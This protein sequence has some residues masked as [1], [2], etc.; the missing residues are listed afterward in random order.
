MLSTLF[1]LTLK[2]Y[3]VYLLNIYFSQN[4]ILGFF[5]LRFTGVKYFSISLLQILFV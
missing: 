4:F 5:F 3:L 1:I 2:N